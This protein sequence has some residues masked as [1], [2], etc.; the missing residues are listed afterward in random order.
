MHIGDL[1][2]QRLTNIPIN[3]LNGRNL[4]AGTS[5]LQIDAIQEK[6]KSPLKL[7]TPILP[8]ILWILKKGPN[9]RIANLVCPLILHV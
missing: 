1:L 3:G 5:H 2:I 9:L 4:Y 7:A 8:L 6:E